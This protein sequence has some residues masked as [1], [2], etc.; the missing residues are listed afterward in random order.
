MLTDVSIMIVN[1]KCCSGERR[2]EQFWAK[3]L[4]KIIGAHGSVVE[5]KGILPSGEII[6]K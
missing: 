1:I 6:Y 4:K 2:I 5:K 3:L